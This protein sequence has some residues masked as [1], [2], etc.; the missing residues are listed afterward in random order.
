MLRENTITLNFRKTCMTFRICCGVLG[1][2]WDLPL[3]PGHTDKELAE[4]FNKFFI[5]KIVNIR[6]NLK[7][8]HAQTII[9]EDN[10]NP[11]SFTQFKEL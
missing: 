7:G 1:R 2:K 11:P 10:Y 3:P 8:I 5:I 9:A 6:N 4:R